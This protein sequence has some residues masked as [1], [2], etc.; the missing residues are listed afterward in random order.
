MHDDGTTLSGKRLIRFEFSLSPGN[1]L[2][3]SKK[4]GTRGA[5]FPMDAHGAQRAFT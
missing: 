5:R 2:R 3:A 4:T 1:D